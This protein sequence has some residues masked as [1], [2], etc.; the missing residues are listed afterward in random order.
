MP[1]LYR[2]IGV[3][4]KFAYKLC[5][6]LVFAA[7]AMPLGAADQEKIDLG[8]MREQIRMLESVLNTSLNQSFPGPFA[9]LDGARGAYLPGYGVVFTFEVNLSV[10]RGMA[11]PFGGAPQPSPKVR[12]DEEKQRRDQA[13]AMAEKV[14]AD[15][16]HTVEQLGANESLAIVIQGAAVGDHGVEKSTMVLRA[17]KHDIDGLRANTLDR[18]A[19]LRKLQVL[20]Y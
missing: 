6:V 14:I 10:N 11:G 16:G 15:F 18:A 9:Y 3:I 19:F 20:E 1:R 12:K 4:M 13:R 2:I 8:K 7:L 5:A 17:S